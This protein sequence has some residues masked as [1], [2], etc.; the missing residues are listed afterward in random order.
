MIHHVTREIGPAQL[1]RCRRFYEILGFR[2]VPVPT[3]IA[4]RALW[5]E[6]AGSQV[7]LMPRDDAQ[8]QSGH[9]GIVVE[10]YAETIDELQREGYEIDPRAEHWGSPRAYVRDPGGNLV[11]LMAFPPGT[12]PSAGP[13][14][15]A[16]AR[17]ATT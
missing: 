5:L 8:V 1:E 13:R 3:G 6:R 17:P 12:D 16:A 9:V 11:E 14:S 4:G 7:H 10:R 2:N 15:S